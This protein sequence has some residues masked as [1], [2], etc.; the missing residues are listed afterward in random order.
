MN[1]P[2]DDFGE[3]G[4]GTV[5]IYRRHGCFGQS[6]PTSIALLEVLEKRERHTPCLDQVV[7]LEKEEERHTP[8]HLFMTNFGETSQRLVMRKRKEGGG[9][10]VYIHI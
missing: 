9:R 4:S 7:F 3:R 1:W 5:L 10:G 8:W 6:E 2:F